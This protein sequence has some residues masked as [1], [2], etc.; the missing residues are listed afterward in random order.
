MLSS[1]NE[2]LIGY[3]FDRDGSEITFQF[4]IDREKYRQVDRHI[5][6]HMFSY[7]RDINVH[8]FKKAAYTMS[9]KQV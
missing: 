5:Q 7:E 6:I 3:G 2:A 4:Q 1:P 8:L 9:A